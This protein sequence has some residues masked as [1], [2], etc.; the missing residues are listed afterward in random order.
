MPTTG[1]DAPSQTSGSTDPTTADGGSTESSGSGSSESSESS[2]DTTG[3]EGACE[4]MLPPPG[5]CFAA[6]DPSDVLVEWLPYER[7]LPGTPVADAWADADEA[8]GGGGSGSTGGSSGG[9]MGGS[10]D[11]GFIG[12]IEDPDGGGVSFEC[13]VIAQDC[14]A[15]EKCMPWANDG[16]GSWNATR[17]S[18]VEVAPDQVGDPCTVEGSG[19]SGIDSCDLG[20]MCWD[21]DAETNLGT[22]VAMCTCSFENPIC[23]VPNTVCSISNDGALALCLGVC[24]PL[25]PDACAEGQGC[26]PA[27]DLF[28]CVPDASGDQGAPGDACQYINAC[29]SGSVCLNS[30]SVPGGCGG[31][32]CC[33]SMC[34]IGDDSGCLAGQSCV[35]WYS[36]GAEPGE[37]LGQVGVCSTM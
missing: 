20:Q 21:V 37:C 11:G 6:Q 15:G 36:E 22:C 13:D 3:G 7:S 33:S 32:N 19:T 18:P 31:V 8:L 24:N 26:Y 17:C 35:P 9:G 1:D 2:G 23:D 25:D 14:P 12:F 30:N 29:D 10:T 5:A 27:A 28:Q 34:T 4:V 16:G